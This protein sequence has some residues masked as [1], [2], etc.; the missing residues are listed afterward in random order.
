MPDSASMPGRASRN[1]SWDKLVTEFL[2]VKDDPSTLQ[3]FVNTILGQGWRGE[4]E[5]LA[6]EELAARGE[7]WGLDKVPAEVLALT[8]GCDVQHDRLEITFTGWAEEGTAWVLGHRVI[9]GEWDAPETW[10]ALDD[11]LRSRF[12]HA[13]G[14]AIGLDACAVDAGD[15]TTMNAVTAFCTP[16]L[17]R[18]V[19]AIKGAAGNR[20]L[21]ERAGSKT[22][23]G[24]RLWIVGVDTAK[25]Q[26]FARLSRGASI[27]LSAE[28]PRVWHEQVASERAILRY[29][30]GQPVR[31][32]RAHPRPAGRGAGLPGLCAGGAADHRP[33]LGPAAG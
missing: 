1:A 28:L 12:P 31:E 33:G 25:T 2:S 24:A 17:R 3:T 13:L 10:T 20:P 4:G 11:L 9:W 8:A 18:K 30:R 23:T 6:D 21:I 14:G 22:K 19:V 32:L 27:R 7:D 16:R 26:L 29:R 5:E 15:G